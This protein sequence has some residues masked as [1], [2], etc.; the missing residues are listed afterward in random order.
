MNSLYLLLLLPAIL[1]VGW[2]I[3][4]KL[5]EHKYYESVLI[6]IP[7]LASLA[8][9]LIVSRMMSGQSSPGLQMLQMLLG[10][11]IVPLAYLYFSRQLGRRF[12]NGT[13]LL[14]WLS[15]LL[16]LV[17]R[18]VIFCSAEEGIVES[19]LVRPFSIEFVCGGQVVFWL[20]TGDVILIVQAFL[21]MLRMVPTALTLRRYGLRLDKKVY[22]FGIWWLMTI[23]FIATVSLNDISALSLPIGQLYY[24]GGMS[25][26]LSTIY[27]L[28][29]LH[30]D[31]Q[32]VKTAEGETVPNLDSYI[33]H[34]SALSIQVRHI[35][36]DDR[37][38]LQPGYRTE[39]ILKT[40]TTNRTYFT[41][42]MQEEFGKTFSQYLNEHRLAHAQQL[43]LTTDLTQSDIAQQSG[44]SD[45]TYMSRMFKSMYNLTP[46][47]WQQANRQ[48]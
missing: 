27:L 37:V 38:Y 28:I 17:P 24:F 35:V 13:N 23:L 6:G 42:M 34:Q 39:D 45:V 20:F 5:K 2:A 22:A 10:S 41:R 40:L 18:C 26:I 11:I 9:A 31:L 14:L 33:G 12:H 43:L 19:N 1:I 30:F 25:L 32:P 47:Q 3:Y 29:A 46:R 21:T 36:E 8:D 4:T 44:F 7:G 15:L 16:L 48:S